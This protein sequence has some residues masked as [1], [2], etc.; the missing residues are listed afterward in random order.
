MTCVAVLTGCSMAI[1][2]D[3]DGTLD[4]VTGGTLRVGVS[5]S[6]PWVETAEGEE[7][8]GTEPELIREFAESI[9]AEPEWTEDGEERLLQAL[10]RGE[11]DVVIGGFTDQT[12]WTDFGALTVPYAEEE[13]DGSREKH[14]MV[15]RMGE[16]AFLVALERFLLREGAS[17]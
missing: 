9:G 15:V 10:E 11:L 3:P 7:P 6:P 16:N 5:E 14:V 12:P 13:R 17:A 1:P 8:A 2:A 4:R